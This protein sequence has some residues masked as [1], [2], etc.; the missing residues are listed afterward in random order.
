MNGIVVV[1]K[2]E[3][4]TSFDVV[5]KL[6]GALRVKR[7]GHGGTLDPMATGVLPVFVGRATRAAALFESA[8]KEYIAGLRLGITTDTQDIT[9]SVLAENDA[10]VTIEQL[11]DVLDL[12]TGETDQLPP[13]YSAI[14]IGGQPLYKSARRG[15]EV[16]RAARRITV[17][18]LEIISGGGRDYVL[19]CAVSKGTYI[20]ALCADIGEKLGCGGVMSSLRRTRAGAFTIAD[21]LPLTR[22]LEQ[23]ALGD[24]SFLR[25]TDTLFGDRPAITVD[26][27]DVKKLRNGA[28]FSVSGASDGEY[29]VYGADGGFLA[30]CRCDG[31]TLLT[32]RSFFEV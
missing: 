20:R 17:S 27:D 26:G 12:F 23:N 32:V 1:D 15:V 19:R 16:E 9:G 6:R 31:G 22:I 10:P 2:P 13:M 29:R 3:G 14:K 18:E 8:D 30:L 21:A 28:A 5:A 7:V 25:G 11:R 24:T 4:W